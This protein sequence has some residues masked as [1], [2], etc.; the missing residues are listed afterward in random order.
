MNIS[1]T[2]NLGSGKSS[3]C[4]ILREKGYD[5]IS[6][7][8]IFRDLAKE[9]HMSVEDFNKKV[10]EDIQRGDHSVDDLIDQRTT[11]IDETRDNVI[12]D[13]RLAWHFA[14]R[15]YKVFVT[16]DIDEAAKRVYQDGKRADSESYSSL[17]ECKNALLHRQ[18]LERQ[19]FLE[20]YQ[21]N[22]FDQNNYDLVVD[23]TALTPQ[24][25]AERIVESFVLF[26]QSNQ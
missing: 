23:S 26:Q 9:H 10:N 20:L 22:Y 16:V 25:V 19:R 17:E 24:E 18:E 7:G 11:K 6:A 13:S 1:I 4:K 3:I 2:G 12:F 14:P 5:I 21:I 8:T 15:S